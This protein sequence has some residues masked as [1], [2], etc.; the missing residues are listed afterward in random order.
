MGSTGK[1]ALR[2][3]NK[4][5]PHTWVMGEQ[6]SASIDF[7]GQLAGA[8]DHLYKPGKVEA[9]PSPEVDAQAYTARDRIRRLAR[10]AQGR[11][12]TMRTDLQA[13]P[14]QPNGKR[15]TGS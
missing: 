15:L 11:D 2:F 7:A 4:T 14:Y 9:L 12:S 5:M 3:A 10:T 6:N 1:K 8:H 13:A